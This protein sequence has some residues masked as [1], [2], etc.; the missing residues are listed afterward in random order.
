MPRVD[1][2]VIAIWKSSFRN[3]LIGIKILCFNFKMSLFRWNP[4]FTQWFPCTISKLLCSLTRLASEVEK[5]LLLTLTLPGPR[6]LAMPSPCGVVLQR[7]CRW[8]VP[9]KPRVVSE[10]NVTRDK[11]LGWV[12]S[13]GARPVFF[14]SDGQWN[15]S[16]SFFLLPCHTSYIKN[17]E[18]ITLHSSVWNMKACEMAWF[19]VT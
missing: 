14:G 3:C 12:P 17:I 7:V 1:P 6:D 9:V 11:L 13:F 2:K 8:Q 19:G 5:E 18:K 16:L 15:L 10:V 4:D